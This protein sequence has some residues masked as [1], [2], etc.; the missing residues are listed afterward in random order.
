MTKKSDEESAHAEANEDIP[1]AAP[2]AKNLPPMQHQEV[3]EKKSK[4]DGVDK[5]LEMMDEYY[6]G[7]P[8]PNPH[9]Q[10]DDDHT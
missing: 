9:F 5:A 7:V 4:K 2:P 6:E 1:V 8:P 10:H 3:K